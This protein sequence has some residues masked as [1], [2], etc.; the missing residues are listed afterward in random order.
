MDDIAICDANIL[1]DFL[2]VLD[3]K[4]AIRAMAVFFKHVYVPETVLKEVKEPYLSETEA[5]KLGLDIYKDI[6]LELLMSDPSSKGLSGQDRAC[7]YLV[8]TNGWICITNDKLLRA[9]CKHVGGTVMWGLE[10][11]LELV[12]N[13]LLSETFAKDLADQVKRSNK[14]ISGVVLREFKEKVEGLIHKP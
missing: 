7:L 5:E 6:P 13:N 3:G 8:R 1:I 2:S 10:L 12:R 11:V 9:N 14:T 4:D